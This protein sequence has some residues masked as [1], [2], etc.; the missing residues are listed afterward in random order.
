MKE[1]INKI[2][3][4]VGKYFSG[5]CPS[6]D[7]SH[8]DRVYDL[9]QKIADQFDLPE[10]ERRERVLLGRLFAESGFSTSKVA[11]KVVKHWETVMDD[12]RKKIARKGIIFSRKGVKR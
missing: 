6:H 1:I 10:E 9:A 7:W 3:R 8:V 4:D 12:K 11:D 2:K 5:S